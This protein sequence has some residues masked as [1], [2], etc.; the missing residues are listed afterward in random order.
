MTDI[1][2]AI[3]YSFKSQA[4]LKE[5]LTHRSLAGKGASHN[6]RLEFLGDAVL[7]L[8][9]THAL[10]LQL[11]ESEEGH[12]TALRSALVRG[13]QLAS[14]SE[15]LG[16]GEA[17]L[18]S[19]GERAT[20]GRAKGYLLANAFEAIVG[21]V[22]LDGGLVAAER[23][24]QKL[25]MPHLAG[26]IETGSHIDAKS[27]LQE[28]AQERRSITPSYS[29]VSEEGPDHKKIFTMAVLFGQE[30]IATGTGASKQQAETAAAT[31]ALSLLKW[32]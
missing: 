2:R 30:Q 8:V 11:P 3:G 10:F 15:K 5:A 23:M 17:L 20:G 12:M 13:S 29:K 32:K 31:A 18:L 16:V 7:E 9:V 21:A 6:E 14:I 25:V 4:L 24:V 22:Y 1:E 26:I 19:R 28:L 27:R